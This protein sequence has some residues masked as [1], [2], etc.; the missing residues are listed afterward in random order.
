ME[1]VRAH[2]HALGGGEEG[3][4]ARH[5]EQVDLTETHLLAR[6]LLHALEALGA[7]IVHVVHDGHLVPLAQHLE[8]GVAANEARATRDEDLHGSG[9]E[10]ATWPR[11]CA[12]QA[13]HFCDRSLDIYVE[14][15]DVAV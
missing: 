14:T 15:H 4:H 7:R 11:G 10:F 1:R 2:E 5:V 13:K 6:K 3:L 12:L 9:F 8:Y